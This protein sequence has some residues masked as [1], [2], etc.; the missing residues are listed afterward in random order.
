MTVNIFSIKKTEEY[1]CYSFFRTDNYVGS[2][3]S[4]F[5]FT[6]TVF[7]RDRGATLRLGGHHSA[8]VT[9]Y[10]G[11]GGMTLFLTKSL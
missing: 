10:W 2:I 4:Q 1:I 9:Q 7:C 8:L 6:P 11:E 5:L 3:C